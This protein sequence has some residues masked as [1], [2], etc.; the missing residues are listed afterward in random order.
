MKKITVQPR[1]ISD[2]MRNAFLDYSMSVIISRALP[3]VRDGLKPVHRKILYAMDKMGIR[4]SSSYKKSARIVGEV[5]GKYHP[6]GDQAVYDTMVRMAQSFSMRYQ[7][8]DGQGNYGS[9]DGDSPAHMRYT[10]ARM[11][12]ISEEMLKDLDKETVDF[13]DNYD[14]TRQEPTV[15]PAKLPQLLLNGSLGIAVGMATSIPPHNLTEVTNACI[16]LIDNPDADVD[17]LMKFVTGPDFPTGGQ[18]FDINAI[19]QAYATGKGSIVLRGLAS[20]QEHKSGAY[21]IIISE[22]PYQVNKATLI[23]KIADLVKDKKLIGIR[24]IRDESGREEEIRVVIELKRDAFPKK[25]LNK[26]YQLTELQTSFH[27][28]MLALV[29]GIQPRVLSLKGLLEQFLKHREQ[30]VTKRTKFELKQA[31]DRAHILEGLK[32]ALDHIDAIIKTI[33]NSRTK[34]IAHK[35]LRAKF[36]L[37]SKQATAILEMK[38]QTLAGLE[39]KKIEDEL[40]EKRQ[41]IAKLESILKSRKKILDIVKNEIAEIKDRYGD[42]RRTKVFRQRAGEFSE[43][44]LVANEDVVI[45]LT[46]S[47][48]VKRMPAKAYKAQGRGGKGVKGMKIKEED[49][50]DFVAWTMTHKDILFFTNQGRVFKTKAYEIPEASRQAKGQALVNFLQLA[51]EE[52]VTALLSLDKDSD[53]THLVMV[54]KKGLV[55]RVLIEQFENVR[56]SGLIAI[57]LKPADE[58]RWVAATNGQTHIMIATANGQAIRFEEKKVRPMGRTAAGVRAMRL[59]GEDHVIGMAKTNIPQKLLFLLFPRTVTVN[60]PI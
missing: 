3:D 5:L 2:E 58:L 29:D 7:L 26:L 42:N 10:E 37:S 52:K 53:S 24:D 44:D 25:V 28:N 35:N 1:E 32:K 9:V 48:Y 36:N 50:V 40:T 15:L 60:A 51:P 4:Y 12:K 13:Q 57:K 30:V 22:L 11:Q 19:K 31:K 14:G 6:H 46:K 55:K 45:T 27:F 16:H 33:K 41:L 17:D 8:V 39:R 34:E 38:L 59:K 49:M 47:G 43:E 23:T 18:I 54:T 21:Q 56:Q 20:I